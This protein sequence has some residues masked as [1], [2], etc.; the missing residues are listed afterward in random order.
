MND[1]WNDLM[2]NRIHVQNLNISEMEKENFLLK[3]KIEEIIAINKNELCK[4]SAKLG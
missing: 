1:Y 3:H 4:L 2:S